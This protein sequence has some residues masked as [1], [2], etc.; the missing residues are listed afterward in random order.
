MKTLTNV[1]DIAEVLGGPKGIARMTFAN[2]HAV[3]NWLGAFKAFPPNTYVIMTEALKE[4][5]YNALPRLWKMRGYISKS[6][7]VVSKSSKIRSKVSSSSSGKTHKASNA[8]KASQRK[9]P[10]ARKATRSV[11]AR[12]A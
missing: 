9:A 5:G 10:V 7:T 3:N 6:R 11:S 8:R 1:A 2:P 12:R 4:L